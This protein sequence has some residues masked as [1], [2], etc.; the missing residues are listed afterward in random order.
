MLYYLLYAFQLSPFLF[1]DIGMLLRILKLLKS[2]L[3]LT[4][5]ELWLVL[6]LDWSF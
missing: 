6:P 5:P 1:A 4:W 3:P 2:V